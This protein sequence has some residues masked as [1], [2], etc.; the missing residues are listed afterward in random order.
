MTHVLVFDSSCAAC[1]R[2]ARAVAEM[3]I[4]GLEVRGLSDPDVL[5]R[6]RE[7]G[8]EPPDR[9]ALLSGDGTEARLATGWTMRRRLAGLVGWRRARLI[10]RL[11]S[12]ETRARTER[13]GSVS[14]RRVIG[15]GV[16]MA[17]GAVASG[18]LP[19]AA[20]AAASPATGRLVP[21]S[22][23]E[24]SRAL[25]STAVQAA[26]RTWG[27]AQPVGVTSDG[28]TSVLV[29]G[30]ANAPDVALLVDNADGKTALAV[31]KDPRGGALQ[32]FGVDGTAFGTVSVKG[33]KVVA[34]QASGASAAA[35]SAGAAVPAVHIPT[36]KIR[37]FIHCL[38]AHLQASCI[39]TCHTCV[40]T[41][42]PFSRVVACAHCLVC[43]GPE[44]IR[45]A[46]HCF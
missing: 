21:A 44:A 34:T 1:S 24:A 42:N 33:G 18:L 5:G 8:L 14:R 10:V 35:S 15:A 16:A 4:A 23:A 39:L 22:N 28:T 19:E 13:S 31:R 12:I 37:C 27:A 9:P 40:T 25:G 26:V 6:L 41:P 30:F 32:F 46:R 3:G 29:L 17:A 43:A 38:G 45:C 11:V 20:A 2:A 7:A 36:A